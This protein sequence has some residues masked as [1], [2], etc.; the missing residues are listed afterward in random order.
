MN[1]E[2]GNET[3]Q[4]HFWEYCFEIFGTVHWQYMGKLSNT[5]PPILLTPR[6]CDEIS[7]LKYICKTTD[8]PD[9]FTNPLFFSSSP[10]NGK[11]S[12]PLWQVYGEYW[13]IPSPK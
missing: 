10:E 5:S 11:I 13:Q 12:I 8:D 2:I 1:V 9:I 4:F 7:V 3:A 6:F